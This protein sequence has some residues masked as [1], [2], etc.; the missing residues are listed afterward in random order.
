MKTNKH[1]ATIETITNT[2][3]IA[4]SSLGV[5]NVGKGDYLGLVLIVFAA[6]LEWFK[7]WGRS[8]KLW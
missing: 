8:K 4:I 1:K 5:M 3:A 2:T 6:G 7:Y